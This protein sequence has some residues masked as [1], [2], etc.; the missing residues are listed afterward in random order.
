MRRSCMHF[1]YTSTKHKGEP[2]SSYQPLLS[3]MP[4]K[5]CRCHLGGCSCP[6][7]CCSYCYCCPCPCPCP[8][9]PSLSW[10]THCCFLDYPWSSYP[11]VL[12]GPNRAASPREFHRLLSAPASARRGQTACRLCADQLGAFRYQLEIALSCKVV[13]RYRSCRR[14]THDKAPTMLEMHVVRVGLEARP[15]SAS[16]PAPQHASA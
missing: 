12:P 13:W 10:Q 16:A 11:T 8:S 14:R 2:G 3:M 5:G 9:S 1:G 7:A 15:G 6:S 4:R